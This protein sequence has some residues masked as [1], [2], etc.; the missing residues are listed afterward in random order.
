MHFRKIIARISN[1]CFSFLAGLAGLWNE[2]V[3]GTCLIDLP[4]IVYA[5]NK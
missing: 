2:K 4:E 5:T 3:S 1:F